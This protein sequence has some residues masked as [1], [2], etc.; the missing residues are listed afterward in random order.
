MV[1]KQS[2]MFLTGPNVIKSVTGEVIDLEGLG[3]AAVHL[4]V[5]GTAHLTAGSDRDALAMARCV[6]GYFPSNNIDNPPYLETGDDPNRMDEVLN[7][8]VPLDPSM[9]YNMHEVIQRIMDQDSFLELLSTF[10]QNV[11]VG[12]ARLGGYSVGIVA[13]NPT[14][15]AGSMD[16]DSADKVGRFVNL[17]NAFNIPL[18]TFVDS[19]GFLPGVGQEHGGVIRHG[20]K[21]LY[22]YSIATSPKICVVTRKAIGGA[23]VVLSSKYMGADFVYA[24]PSAQIAVMGEDGAANILWGK[25]IEAAQDKNA[26]RAR[27]TEEYRKR[28]MNPYNSAEAGYVDDIIEPRETRPVLISALVALRDKHEYTPPRKHGNMPV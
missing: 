9:P 28:F 19:P 14:D 8:I 18:I 27:L 15:K 26:E 23:Y 11:I 12:F 21:V 2:Y 1:E 5:S 13:N 16:I 3:G 22:A 24:W 20:A 4:G 10:A 25:Q 17:C 7:G 6:L